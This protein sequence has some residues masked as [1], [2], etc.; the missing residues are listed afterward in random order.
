MEY[1]L[2]GEKLSHSYSPQIHAALGDYDY[3]LCPLSPEE[4]NHFLKKKE[5][6]GINVTIPYKKDV[7]P[8]C[9]ALSPEAEAIQSVNTIVKQ[10]DGTLWGHNTDIAGFIAMLN[11][12][13]IEAEG[14][15]AVILGSGGTSQTAQVALKMMQAREIVVISRTGKE[16]YQT[17]YQNHADAQ[18][19]INTTPVGMYPANGLTPVD[20]DKLPCLESVADVIYNPEK[21]ALLL[22]AEERKLKCISGL[23]MLV[24]QARKAAELFTGKQLSEALDDA[25]VRKIKCET[26]NLVFIGMPGCGKSTIGQLVAQKMNRPLIDTD[27]EIEKKA[28]KTI[29]QIFAEDGEAYFRSLEADVIHAVCAGHGAVITTG[30]G[31]VLRKENRNAIRQ[32]SR[33]CFLQRPLPLLSRTGRPLSKDADAVEALWKERKHLYL[34]T[35]DFIVENNDTAETAAQR[36]KEGFYEVLGD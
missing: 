13:G 1:G 24:A 29:P 22:Q 33:V 7:I 15:K 21:T 19:L 17:L 32:N 6:R 4:L 2:I 3:R 31:S 10:P 30:G 20:L 36:A 9:D 27:A 18:L 23:H 34:Q 11:R 5:F 28:G 8:Y 12:A 26:L 25:I 14:K 35:A 16:N